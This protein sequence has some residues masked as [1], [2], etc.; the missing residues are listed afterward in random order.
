MKR[1]RRQDDSLMPEGRERV[2]AF[3]AGELG[4]SVT[5]LLTPNV[6]VRVSVNPEVPGVLIFSRGRDVRICASRTK[7]EEIGSRICD[8]VWEDFCSPVF[9]RNTFPELCE[10]CVGP[11][12]HFYRDAIPNDWMTAMCGPRLLVRELSEDDI[13]PIGEFTETLSPSEIEASGLDDFERPLWGAFTHGA[14][15]A[16]ASFDEWPNRFAHIGVATR[17]DYRGQRFAQA[18]VRGATRAAVARKRVVQMQCPADNGAAVG[19]AASL[20]YECFATT[21]LIHSPY[22]FAR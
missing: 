3:W 15:V 2:F 17:P 11:V 18:A 9:W 16:I 6:G 5:G 10:S 7:G 4:L 21:L 14:L 1:V 22:G 12:L 8:A 13:Q 19:L 20:G